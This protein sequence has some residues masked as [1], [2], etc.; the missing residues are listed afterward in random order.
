MRTVGALLI[1]LLAVG[2][3]RTAR[4]DDPL[5]PLLPPPRIG[6]EMNYTR[7]PGAENCPPF[8]TM[9]LLLI[10][11]YTYDPFDRTREEIHV[12]VDVTLSRKNGQYHGE[13]T[14]ARVPGEPLWV[15]EMDG[16]RCI[17]VLK[18]IAN[19][20]PIYTYVLF[21]PPKPPP[22]PEA[23]TPAPAPTPPPAAPT[24]PPATPPRRRLEGKTEPRQAPEPPLSPWV[25][26]LEPSIAF[27]LVP[28]IGLGGALTFA[29]RWESY[30]IVVSAS[31]FAT[32]GQPIEGGA[33]IHGD[34]IEGAVVPCRLVTRVPWRVSVSLCA[35]V[36][37]GSKTLSK[38]STL[39]EPVSVP[40]SVY[41]SLGVGSRVQIEKDFGRRFIAGGFGGLGTRLWSRTAL[42]PP[43]GND[44]SGSNKPVDGY[45]DLAHGLTAVGIFG[46][47]LGTRL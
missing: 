29:H 11:E 40:T 8:S 9:E 19:A 4:A 16:P 22:P 42:P 23:P 14:I 17:E 25:V 35:T 1:A 31:W 45:G 46:L 5:P 43:A 47:Y 10:G 24:T 38:L 34:F 37:F 18:D 41:S 3:P 32:V 26:S 21:P 2:L 36:G 33:Y 27:G 30:S 39:V 44:A 15:Q 7:K 13:Y 6:M 28:G 12:F 20:T